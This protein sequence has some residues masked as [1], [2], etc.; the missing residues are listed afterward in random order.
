MFNFKAPSQGEP[1]DLALLSQMA[2]YVAN[3]NQA[4]LEAKS[5]KS[6]LNS[7]VRLNV[8]TSD[9]TIWT[10]KVLVASN[11]QPKA[12]DPHINWT[13]PFDITFTSV[14]IVTA[15]VYCDTTGGGTIAP[16]AVW[17]HEITP[18]GVKGKFKWLGDTSKTETVYVQ[19]IAIGQGVVS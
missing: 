2:Q 12:A 14:P 11:V 9:V 6:S 16:S 19:V 18:T 13:A 10:G 7:A 17:L 15:T 5:S 4:V 1:I 3:I 8:D